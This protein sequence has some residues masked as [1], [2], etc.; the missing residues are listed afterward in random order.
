M[1]LLL[2]WQQ[3]LQSGDKMSAGKT[4]AMAAA[5]SADSGIGFQQCWGQAAP[6]KTYVDGWSWDG[7]QFFVVGR[8]EGR[9]IISEK[10]KKREGTFRAGTA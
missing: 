2:H 5:D 10:K 6:V 9:I 7:R 8:P 4:G 3:Q 1:L